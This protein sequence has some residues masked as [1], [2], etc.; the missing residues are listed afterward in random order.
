M[1]IYLFCMPRASMRD[2]VYVFGFLGGLIKLQSP[3]VTD[4]V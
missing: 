2:K 4:I 1:C 3:Q